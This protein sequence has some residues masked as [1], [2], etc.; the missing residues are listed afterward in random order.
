MCG[1]FLGWV[2]DAAT[3]QDSKTSKKQ[4]DFAKPH[5]TILHKNIV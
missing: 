4:Y 5:S 3:V 1:G 2:S